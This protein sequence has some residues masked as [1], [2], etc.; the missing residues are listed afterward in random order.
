MGSQERIALAA[1]CRH[2]FNWVG[3]ARQLTHSTD[4]YFRVALTLAQRRR[5]AAAILA[6]LFADSLRRLRV[7]LVYAPANAV[8][9]AS[10]P[11]RCIC[12]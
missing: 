12:S 4:P 3:A 8:S 9:A 10:I 5:C 6:R 1:P 2:I 11:A 7:G